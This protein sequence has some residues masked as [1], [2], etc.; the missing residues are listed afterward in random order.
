MSRSSPLPALALMY[1]PAFHT[2]NRVP[3]YHPRNLHHPYTHV[4]HA[5]FD[6]HTLSIVDCGGRYNYPDLPQLHPSVRSPCF[7]CG[8]MHHPLHYCLDVLQSPAP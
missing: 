1:P 7:D 6:D 5:N 4:L 2:Y 3:V 8:H